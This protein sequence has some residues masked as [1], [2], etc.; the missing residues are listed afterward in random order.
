MEIHLVVIG[1]DIKPDRNLHYVQ[2]TIADCLLDQPVLL[3]AIACRQ[4]AHQRS[5][6]ISLQTGRAIDGSRH[7]GIDGR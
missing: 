5:F 1:L 6:Q 7:V 2:R 4:T 3:E